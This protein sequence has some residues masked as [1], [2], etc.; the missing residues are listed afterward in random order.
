L[1]VSAESG[2][3]FDFNLAP[4]TRITGRVL[5]PG[6]RPLKDVCLEAAPLQGNPSSRSRISDCTEADGSYAIEKLPAGSYRIVANPGGQKTAAA[7]FGPL[8]YPGTPELEK[9]GVLTVVA[10]QHLTGADIQ[11][12]RLAPRIEL[13]GR[14]IFS[15]G[16][17]L[18][19]QSLTFDSTDN[20]YH[21]YSN[22]DA[23]GNF[24]M[25]VLS[26]QT[27]SLLGRIFIFRDVEH[28]CPQFNAKFSPEG[29]GASLLSSPFPV[30]GD[31][32]LSGIEVIFP[33]PSCDAWVKR[34]SPRGQK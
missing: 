1:E 2:N 22:T 4:D 3:G 27:G 23:L 7:P 20:R 18:A 28:A 8:Y 11:V 12:P 16:V 29:H 21:E 14:L 9:A 10:G 34:Y 6:G 25:Q 13:S 15:N 33:F 24:R 5:G 30:A 26:G 17:P 32:S 31:K 19:G